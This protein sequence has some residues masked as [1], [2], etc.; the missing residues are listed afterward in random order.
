MKDLQKIDNTILAPNQ[1]LQTN[2]NPVVQGS[3][4]V[5][6]EQQCSRGAKP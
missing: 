5:G 4:T 1:P 6:K 2:T 3:L